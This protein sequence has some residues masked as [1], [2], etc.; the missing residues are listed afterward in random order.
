MRRLKIAALNAAVV[1]GLVT[2]IE[3]G[4]SLFLFFRDITVMAWEAAPYSDYDP[5]LGWI[6][7]PNIVLPDFWGK[8]IGI[9]TN[10]QRFRNLAD[11]ETRVAPGKTRVICSGDSFTFGDGVDT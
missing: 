10:S 9:R 7:K 11:I 8:G 6:A 4:A 5:E 1:A 2:F 3:G